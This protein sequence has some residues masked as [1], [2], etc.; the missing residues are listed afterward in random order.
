MVSTY[1]KLKFRGFLTKSVTLCVNFF[2][3]VAITTSQVFYLEAHNSAGKATSAA[4]N[5]ESI[6]DVQD[7][8]ASIGQFDLGEV[9]GGVTGFA[10]AFVV[11]LLLVMCAAMAIRWREKAEKLPSF[12]S[13]DFEVEKAG[14]VSSL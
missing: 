6:P 4:Q 1:T 13:H 2:P 8:A 12:L 14:V 10:V 9:V 7:P 11:L 3:P 5:L